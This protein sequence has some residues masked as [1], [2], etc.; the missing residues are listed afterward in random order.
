MDQIKTVPVNET[1]CEMMNWAVRY[2]LGRRTYAVISVCS[3]VKPL[4]PLLDNRTLWCMARDIQTQ[5][6]LGDECDKESWTDLFDAVNRE[7]K[8]R[9]DNIIAQQIG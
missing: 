2:A 6:D 4:L 9:T 3:Y 7:L 8:G 1:F 5:E